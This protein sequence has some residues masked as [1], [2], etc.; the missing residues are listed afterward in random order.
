M[1]MYNPL[2]SPPMPEWNGLSNEDRDQ[3]CSDWEVWSC[4]HSC[5]GD[6]FNYYDAIREVLKAREQRILKATMEFNPAPEPPKIT[7]WN[8]LVNFLKTSPD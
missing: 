7:R 6:A 3:L 4:P 8:R 2:T 1:S 5:G